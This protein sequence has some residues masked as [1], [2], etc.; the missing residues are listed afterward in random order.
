[1]SNFNNKAIPV[2]VTV[3]LWVKQGADVEEVISDMDYRFEHEDLVD[4]EIQ[5]FEINTH[6]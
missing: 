4:A 5:E 3:T 2:Q 1:M 6:H